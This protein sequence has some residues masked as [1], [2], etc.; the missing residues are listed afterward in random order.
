LSHLLPRSRAYY[1]ASTAHLLEE[2]VRMKRFNEAAENIQL[3]HKRRAVD[4]ELKTVESRVLKEL[5]ATQL[6]LASKTV[7]TAVAAGISHTEYKKSTGDPMI[8]IL[9]D[10]TVRA[11]Y[12]FTPV[13]PKIVTRPEFEKLISTFRTRTST[14]SLDLELSAAEIVR[15]YFMKE[16]NQDQG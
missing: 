6:E 7:A 13:G 2:R 12:G 3:E 11:S 4:H 5:A 15:R 1:V 10:G 9:D 14:D 8:M 16:F